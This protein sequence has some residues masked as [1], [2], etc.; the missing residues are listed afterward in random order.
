[1]NEMRPRFLALFLLCAIAGA[2]ARDWAQVPA[3]ATI[4][5]L[6]FNDIHAIDPIDGGRRGGLGRV[7][8][9]FQQLKRT[10]APVL[11]TLGGDY[12][13]PSACRRSPPR[14]QVPSL[15]RSDR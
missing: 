9:L 2:G 10:H 13:S 4:T 12:L 14:H 3:S 1:M 6:H 8:T 15:R 7:S 11:I 5:I